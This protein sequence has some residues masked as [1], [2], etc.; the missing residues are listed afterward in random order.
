[1]RGFTSPPATNGCDGGGGRGGHQIFRT[2]LT[3][4]EPPS[5]EAEATRA[6]TRAPDLPFAKSVPGFRLQMR[7]AAIS[8]YLAIMDVVTLRIAVW[9]FYADSKQTTRRDC[10]PWAKQH[11]MDQCYLH[12]MTV[13][14]GGGAQVYCWFARLHCHRPNPAWRLVPPPS[15]R[16]M[17]NTESKQ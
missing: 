8:E 10:P 13:F 7:T 6:C 2:S 17:I 4:P 15:P 5:W 3:E 9:Y 1:V 11:S 12:V 14:L 16:P